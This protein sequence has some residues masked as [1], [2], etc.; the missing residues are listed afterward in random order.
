MEIWKVVFL[1]INTIIKANLKNKTLST[2]ENILL[3]ILKIFIIE[4]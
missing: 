4:I 1:G 3:K 2:S